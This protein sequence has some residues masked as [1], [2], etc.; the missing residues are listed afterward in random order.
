MARKIVNRKDKRAE[1]EAAERADT[2]KTAKKA[3]KAPRKKS[4]KRVAETRVRL[5]WGVFNHSM[6]RVALFDF[7]Q[8]KQAEKKAEELTKSSKN[9]HFVQRVKE[10]V[11]E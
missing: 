9:P 2:K 1:V 4:A 6:K 11:Q 7:N 5:Y 3:P 8:R 10:A